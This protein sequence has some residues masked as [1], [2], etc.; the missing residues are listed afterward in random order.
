M[1]SFVCCLNVGSS[2]F[3]LYSSISMA[4]SGQRN[5]QRRQALHFSGDTT[6][7][8]PSSSSSRTFSGQKATQILQPLH[9]SLSMIISCFFSTGSTIMLQ[10]NSCISDIQSGLVNDNGVQVHFLNLRIGFNDLRNH[11]QQSP[12]S[13]FVSWRFSPDA[14]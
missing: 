7:A 14:V 2:G 5:S 3:D 10:Y 13:L 8:F 11:Q 9:H 1:H 12:Q 6:I 4:T